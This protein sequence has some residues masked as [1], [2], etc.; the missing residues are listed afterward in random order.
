MKLQLDFL[1]ELV[2]EMGDFFADL[3]DVIFKLKILFF[4][5]EV[6]DVF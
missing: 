6:L 5:W 4:D 1:F 3:T 2:A